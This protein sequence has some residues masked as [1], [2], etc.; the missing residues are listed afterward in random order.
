MTITPGTRTTVARSPTERA[1]GCAPTPTSGH[2]R[3]A[4][5]FEGCAS[6]PPRYGMESA[7]DFHGSPSASCRSPS[8]VATCPRRY[9][10]SHRP[11]A[12]SD[13]CAT[14][15]CGR[16]PAWR[17]G[18]SRV[19]TPR[20]VN[21]PVCNPTASRWSRPSS[22]LSSCARR[23][24]PNSSIPAPTSRRRSSSSA[25]S[26]GRARAMSPC[27]RGGPRSSHPMLRSCT[28]RRARSTS[29]RTIS[30]SRRSPPSA[31][32]RCCS[33]PRPGER[34]SRACRFRLRR[35]LAW[36]GWCPTARS[37]LVSRS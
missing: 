26:P 3:A 19:P 27:H 11:G 22:P 15:R 31:G 10:D 16:C 1:S 12:S 8:R 34:I 33:S 24:S 29:T 21:V 17:H 36:R 9:S 37:C 13:A 4:P 2:R 14:A 25:N 32:N 30:S 7:P 20:N 18:E 35:T 28:S 6:N 23:E 5:P